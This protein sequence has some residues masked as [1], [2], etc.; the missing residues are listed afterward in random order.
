MELEK[1]GVRERVE[2]VKIAPGL[3]FDNG[4]YRIVLEP[5]PEEPDSSIGGIALPLVLAARKQDASL[6]TPESLR[7]RLKKTEGSGDLH[8]RKRQMRNATRSS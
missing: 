3:P 5:M 8:K 7:I 4:E 2:Q 1:Q 6:S